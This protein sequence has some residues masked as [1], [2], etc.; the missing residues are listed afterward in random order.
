MAT[1]RSCYDRTLARQGGLMRRHSRKPVHFRMAG[2]P[3]KARF[4][5]RAQRAKLRPESFHECGPPMLRVEAF[6][7]ERGCFELPLM[8]YVLGSSM[9]ALSICY[10]RPASMK[11][12]GCQD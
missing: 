3:L 2:E 7:R 10:R 1:I 4:D 11:K 12:D 8:R 9:C 6:Q 5:F